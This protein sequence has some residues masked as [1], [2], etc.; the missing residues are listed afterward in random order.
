MNLTTLGWDG[1]WAQA[2]A[3]LEDPML[4]PARVTAVHRGRYAVRGDDILGRMGGDEFVV[5]CPTADARAAASI[6][7]R[8]RSFSRH[9][10]EAGLEPLWI[11]ASIGVA[12]YSPELDGRPSPQELL[13]RADAAMYES[14]VSG[15][16][17]VSHEQVQPPSL[18]HS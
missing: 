13:I 11:S 12:T 4:V 2:L 1:G 17:N 10:I 16:D 15:K 9:Q 6:A 8:L 3:D 5:I 18:E 14:K 7:E